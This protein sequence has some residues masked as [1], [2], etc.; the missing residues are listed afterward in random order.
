[1]PG[2]SGLGLSRLC[3]DAAQTFR[4]SRVSVY[5][6]LACGEPGPRTMTAAGRRLAVLMATYNGARFIDEQLR[7]V[8]QQTWPAIDIWASD[9]GSADGTPNALERWRMYWSKGNFTR[10]PGFWRPSP[11]IS[12]GM[13]RRF[14]KTTR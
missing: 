7:S 9:D 2:L 1:M 14:M 3:G 5:C 12:P 8:D 4:S 6:G 10:L 11:Q 13:S